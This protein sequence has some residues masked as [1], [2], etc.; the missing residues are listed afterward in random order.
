MSNN[1][2]TK[3]AELKEQLIDVLT[4][5][6]AVKPVQFHDIDCDDCV[7]NFSDVVIDEADNRV[8]I[9]IAMWHD[10]LPVHA[11]NPLK[12]GRGK[13]ILPKNKHN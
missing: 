9:E 12:D 8:Y 2:S 4:K 7:F 3:V 1:E 11:E 13:V 6:N 5:L 10:N